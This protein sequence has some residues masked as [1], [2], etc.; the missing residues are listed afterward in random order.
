MAYNVDGLAVVLEP[1]VR[2]ELVVLVRGLQ[3]DHLELAVLPSGSVE[4]SGL[5]QLGRHRGTADDDVGVGVDGSTLLGDVVRHPV[6]A[7][8]E[9]VHQ[10]QRHSQVALNVRGTLRGEEILVVLQLDALP[11]AAEVQATC[12]AAAAHAG[13]ARGVG[14]GLGSCGSASR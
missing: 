7:H 3:L 4:E 1:A 10:R 13:V 9:R 14:G 8:R 6:L 12:L 11:H 5:G 2:D